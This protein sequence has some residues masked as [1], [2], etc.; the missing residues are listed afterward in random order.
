MEKRSSNR[1]LKKKPTSRVDIT[2]VICVILLALVSIATIFSTTYLQYDSGSYSATIMQIAW[3][4]VGAVAAAVVMQLDR[5]TLYHFAPA[6][7][8]LGLI[9][10]VLVLIFYDRELA[11]SNGAHSWITI[12]PLSLQ[13]SELMKVAYIIMMAYLV[14]GYND[15]GRRVGVEDMSIVERVKFDGRFLLKLTL[16][17]MPPVALIIAQNDLGTTLVFLMMFIGIIFVSGITWYIIL[18]A[19]I[20]FAVIAL[21][22]IILVVYQRDLLYYLGFQDYQFA[23]IDSWLNPFGNSANESYQLAQSLKAIGSGG[24]LGKGLG[25]FQVHVPVRESDMIFSTIGENFGFIGASFVV[26]LYFILIFQMISVAFR[27]HDAFYASMVSGVVMMFAFHIVENIGMSIGLL[28]LTGIPLPLISAGG[29]ALITSMISIGLILSIKY[30]EG[31]E[32]SQL[33][34]NPVVRAIRW[35]NRLIP[36]QILDKLT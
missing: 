14:Q 5:E 34:K 33:T 7:Y 23:R 29:T 8:G 16:W 20:F 28:P 21:V 13:P 17:T 18:P 36:R 35:I 2:I 6:A 12:G 27:A 3:F 32:E 9:L 22:L 15:E 31:L 4:A 19:F 10:L 11:V 26:L 1:R 30:N 25:Q 24:I